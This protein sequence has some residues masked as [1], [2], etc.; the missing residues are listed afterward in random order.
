MRATSLAVATQTMSEQSTG[1][2]ANSSTKPAAV[3]GSSSPYS[4]PSGSYW[5]SVDALSISSTT[6]TG[7][8]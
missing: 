8:A 7:L 6:I 1:I 5:P 2:S 4:A 3:S